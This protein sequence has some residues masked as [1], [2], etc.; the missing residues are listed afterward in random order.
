MFSLNMNFKGKIYLIS[1]VLVLL[2]A[3]SSYVSYKMTERLS[4][5]ITYL[6]QTNGKIQN[7]LVMFG[8]LETIKRYIFE[9]G[10]SADENYIPSIEEL[11]DSF[12]KI[13][14]S[15]LVSTKEYSYAYTKLLE[16]IEKYKLNFE[17]AKEQV[18]LNFSLRLELREE[19]AKI[20]SLVSD[21]E[22]G[23]R[24]GEDMLKLIL[25]RKSILEVEK[26]TM[27]FLETDSVSQVAKTAQELHGAQVILE[28]LQ[29]KGFF[30][31]DDERVAIFENLKSFKKL[32]RKI[33][34]HYRTYSMLTKIVMPG[35]ADEIYH[36]SKQLRVMTLEERGRVREEIRHTIEA[37][38]QLSIFMNTLFVLF[39]LGSLFLILSVTLKPLLGLTKMFEELSEAKEDVEIPAYKYDD[40]IGKLIQ[41]A[42]RY[43]QIN[44]ETK[45]L[46]VSM[47]DYQ[48]N[49]ESKVQDEIAMRREREKALIQQSK[50]ASMGEMI[51]SIAHQWRQPLNE[52]SIRIQKLKY[53]YMDEQVNEAYVT[54]FIEKN[55]ATIDFMSKTIDDF[56]NFFRID[57]EKKSFGVKE[58]VEEVVRLQEAQL[59]NYNIEVAIFGEEFF[60]KGF[61]SEFQQVLINIFGNAKDAFVSNNIVSPRVMVKIQENQLSIQDN[62]GGIDPSLLERVFE[63]YFT[64]KEQ[65]E[66]TGIGLYM[67]QMI[68]V[69]NMNGKISMTNKDD[70]ILVTIEFPKDS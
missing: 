32:V 27:R 60:F 21:L 62:A 34:E 2:S 35:N 70:G 67:S 4:D 55:K 9:Y 47:R 12:E 13:D 16:N 11:F 1:F 26:A 43:K 36:Y 45:E 46:V 69:N 42:N 49:L 48:D 41:A 65:G 51:G 53:A 24:Y 54:T 37:N 20:E 63:P 59:K 29:A 39:V 25:L 14:M 31:R 6:S 5:T 44:K 15:T 19:A 18:P 58:S 10:L 3:L 57:K 38:R 22:G 61:K 30:A 23:A 50:L 68:I 52:L 40:E 7:T 17:I 56:R 8:D 28:E 64:T 33:I 66:G